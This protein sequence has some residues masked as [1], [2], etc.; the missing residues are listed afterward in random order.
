MV[1]HGE[2]GQ[3]I[4]RTQQLGLIVVMLAAF[5]EALTVAFNI[6]AIT[7]RFGA[8]AAE[9]GF[10]ATAQGLSLAIA[11]LVG[12]RL[13]ARHSVARLVGIGLVLVGMGRLLALL[14]PTIALMAA[15][16]ALGGLGTGLVVCVVTAAAARTRNPE[17]T[18]GWIN[19]SFGAYLSFLA[20]IVPRVLESGGFVAAYGFYAALA[21][22]GLLWLPF[23]PGGSAPSERR[24][25][26]G[27]ATG[28]SRLAWLDARAGWIALVG[29]GL[30]YLAIA[31]MGAF[32]ERIGVNADVALHTIDRAPIARP[33]AVLVHRG[34]QF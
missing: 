24:A 6:G 17:M 7:A 19:A 16:Q 14:A 34:L 29:L 18:Y 25:V 31:G 1:V 13:I 3:P 33:G 27:S 11:A 10:V 2:A 20:L 12:T 26:V 32:I 15:C 22:F 4:G 9:A 28:E 8:S 23:L 30:F 5:T 21:A